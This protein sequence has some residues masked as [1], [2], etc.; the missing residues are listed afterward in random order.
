M[1]EQ[2]RNQNKSELLV[3]DQN[4]F[5]TNDK[6]SFDVMHERTKDCY[7]ELFN[8]V[9]EA[10]YIH[11]GD[12]TFLNVNNGAANMYG[13]S[14]E[15]LIGRNPEFV[16][17]PGKNDLKKIE[18][19]L[20]RVAET[21]VQQR[22][23][24]WGIKKNG[25][26]FLKEVVSNTGK[27]LGEDVIITTAR[28]I[29]ERMQA[30]KA[31]KESE[32]KFRTLF[33]NYPDA[34]I[35][36]DID[37]GI[38]IDANTA[39]AA[40]L[41][42]PIEEIIGLY[43]YEL[44][45]LNKEMISKGIFKEHVSRLKQHNHPQSQESIVLRK[46]GL[47]VPV[48]ILAS[49][50]TINGR[51]LLLGV[52]RDITERKLNEKALKKSTARLNRA[53]L[54]SKAGNWEIH[55]NSNKVLA[56][57][58]AGK[59]YGINEDSF[60][61]PELQKYTLPEYRPLL[62]MAL[63]NLIEKGEPYNVE[64]KIKRSGSDEILDIHS[65]AEFDKEKNIVFGVVQDVTEHR[66]DE[67]IQKVLYNI[68]G[69]VNTTKDIEEFIS[70]MQHELGTLLDTT[71][72]LIAFYDEETDMLSAPYYKDDND[73]IGVW[74]ASNSLT[75]YVIKQNKPL[76]VTKD[77]LF[78]TEWLRKYAQVGSNSEVWLGVPLREKGKA[79]G[80]F[81]VQSYTDPFAY[82]EKD[83]VMLEFIS[84]QISLTIQRKKAEQVIKAARAKAEE[85]DRLK[86][87]F[88]ANMSH[89]IRTP[90][91]GILGFAEL[92]DD[93][94]LSAE[95]RREFIS[96]I[97]SSSKQLLIV[98]NDII[99]ISKIESQQLNISNVRFNLNELL[100]KVLLTFENIKKNAGKSHLELFLEEGFANRESNIICD[101]V[102]LSQV[103]YNL[104]G[105]ALKFTSTGFVR[106]GYR[107]ENG[108]LLF[109]VK[110]SGKG[111]PEDKQQ[112][113][114]DRFRQVEESN[115]RQFGGTGLGLSISKGLVELMGGKLWVI[116]EENKGST[117][118]FTLPDDIL[119]M[120]QEAIPEPKKEMPDKGFDG[121]TI[122]V[123]EDI[124]SNFHLIKIMLKKT[125][126]TLLYAEDGLQA[127][128][129]C[130]DNNHIDLIL[131]D[132]QMPN[133][134][135]YEATLEIRTFRPDLP[136]IALTAYAFEEDKIRVMNAGCNDFITKPIDKAGL[137]S[138]LSEYL[139]K[140][141][142]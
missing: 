112:L 16:S 111:I 101:D 65:L 82:N 3:D 48:E 131:M 102:R 20:K 104:L 89:E 26:I 1:D 140:E 98:I 4:T 141:K 29:S 21:G 52:F 17:A 119:A 63:Q 80:A 85:S 35:L 142:N 47:E 130:R 45:P 90:M 94:T 120:A 13:Y 135:G 81:V 92:L 60:P 87:A 42:R 78:K 125:G 57:K 2:L 34:T 54:S 110:D 75:G 33:E 118:Y 121:L 126:A 129:T 72:F 5:I 69:A 23:D 116:S 43:Q 127:V 8:S 39:A 88:L 15:E 49:H 107:H 40:M 27:Y 137:I 109:Y 24:F 95:R 123:A 99:D 44:H 67:K 22:F 59:L 7:F 62:D 64:F 79:F 77:D 108:H 36:A 73:D 61:L 28:D 124:Q 58:G 10:I 86:T 139:I 128:K 12:G 46:D 96:V 66:R 71:N 133:L 37:T 18:A 30:E 74:S 25:E 68:S 132:I 91:N 41:G 106:F 84:D 14:R 9:T 31:L 93:D 136:I 114:F 115:T 19:I 70:F 32:G 56:S 83:V 113:I 53:E 55:L 138:K 122:L 100:Y 50:I 97:S 76:L 38:I 103:L 134:N 6:Q 105:N 117:F 11:K 51:P